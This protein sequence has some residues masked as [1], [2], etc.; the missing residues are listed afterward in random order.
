MDF[1]TCPCTSNW[2]LLLAEDVH[3]L[4]MRNRRLSRAGI[5]LSEILDRGIVLV[6][7]PMLHEVGQE[8]IPVVQPIALE[9]GEGEGK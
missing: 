8:R 4:V 2:K 9:I 7:R 6:G 5:A 3:C 1:A